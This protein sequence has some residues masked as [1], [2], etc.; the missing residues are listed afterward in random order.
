MTKRSPV[1]EVAGGGGSVGKCRLANNSDTGRAVSTTAAAAPGRASRSSSVIARAGTSSP[2][3]APTPH[4]PR[5]RSG[6]LGLP[7]SYQ[8]FPDDA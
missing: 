3:A 2:I 6:K 7:N 8:R 1:R 4:V 5:G